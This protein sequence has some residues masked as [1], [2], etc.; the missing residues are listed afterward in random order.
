VDAVL[1]ATPTTDMRSRRSIRWMPAS[2]CSQRFRWRITLDE[3]ARILALTEQTGLKYTMGTKCAGILSGKLKRM[4]MENCW[5]D[6][7]YGEA[8]YL[9]NLVAE[10]WRKT[11]GRMVRTTG[12][13]IRPSRRLTLLGG[14]PHAFDTLRGSPAR[15][16]SRRVCVWSRTIRVAESGA[17]HRSLFSRARAAPPTRSRCPMLCSVR[18]ASTSQLTAR[19]ARSRAGERISRKSF[20]SRIR[21]RESLVWRKLDSPYSHHPD[22]DFSSGHGTSEYYMLLDFLAAVR[23]DRPT[24]IDAREAARSIAPAVCALESLRT[25]KPVDV[26]NTRHDAV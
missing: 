26:R 24:A 13:L 25:G 9:H 22:L 7:F 2:T 1:I 14:G 15:S 6:I 21:Y 18:T 3:I 4:G 16:S 23:D 11:E 20:T 19:R 12:A 5:G 8:E 17:A 10:G